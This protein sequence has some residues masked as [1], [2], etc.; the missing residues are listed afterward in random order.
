MT[1]P[2]ISVAGDARLTKARGQEIVCILLDCDGDTVIDP[3]S[4][5]W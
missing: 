4:C 1:A 3:P 2:D 5:G